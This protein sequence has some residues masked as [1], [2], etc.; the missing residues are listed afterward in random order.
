MEL[1]N[2]FTLI[3]E[4]D[5]R[6][7]REVS[8]T[9]LTKEQ[10]NQA[11]AMQQKYIASTKHIPVSFQTN[12]PID[13]NPTW[14][15]QGNYEFEQSRKRDAAST[16]GQEMINAT[17]HNSLQDAIDMQNA[18]KAQREAEEDAIIPPSLEEMGGIP[19]DLDEY[20]SFVEGQTVLNGVDLVATDDQVITNPV[21]IAQPQAIKS[22][23]MELTE[24]ALYAKTLKALKQE[25]KRM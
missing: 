10:M 15:M 16:F 6:I 22:A 7:R 14:K 23:T 4:N 11:R 25:Y 5:M 3:S 2:L 13:L 9:P 18:I 12:V 21:A 1:P 17:M 24:D 19:K 8:E 20:I